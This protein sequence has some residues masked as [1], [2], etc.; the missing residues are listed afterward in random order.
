MAKPPRRANYRHKL[1]HPLTLQN[2]RKLTTLRDGAN[3]LLDVFE[4]GQCTVGR[5]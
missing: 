4:C 3:V 5:T 2:D 1:T